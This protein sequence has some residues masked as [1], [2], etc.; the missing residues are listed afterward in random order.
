LCIG[1]GLLLLL[2]SIALS[3]ALLAW[4]APLDALLHPARYAITQGTARAPSAYLKSVADSGLEPLNIQ[5]PEAERG[6][7]VVTA[8]RAMQHAV[9]GRNS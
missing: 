5:F 1:A 4:K 2:G 9:R 6:P 7:I 3:G 8:R